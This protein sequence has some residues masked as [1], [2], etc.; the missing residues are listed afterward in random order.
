M[1]EKN[2][3]KSAALMRK[4]LYLFLKNNAN[5]FN[6]LQDKIKKWK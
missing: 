2:I 4:K 3:Y 1:L 6:K 5:N